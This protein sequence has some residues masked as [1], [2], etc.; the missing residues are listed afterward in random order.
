MVILNGIWLFNVKGVDSFISIL[1][2][3]MAELAAKAEAKAAQDPVPIPEV[4]PPGW[5]HMDEMD[6][7]IWVPPTKE[8]LGNDS[9]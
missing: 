6:L 8:I 5:N 4:V 3:E 7:K 9:S 1:F 2:Q